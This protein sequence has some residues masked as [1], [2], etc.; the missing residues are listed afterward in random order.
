MG[1]GLMELYG[2]QPMF[3][4]P[5]Y[6]F[7]VEGWET[8]KKNLL[9]LAYE[10]NKNFKYHNNN[11]VSSTYDQ[12]PTSMVEK[13]SFIF[14]Q[15]IRLFL[16]STNLQSC[17]LNNVWFQRAQQGDMHDVHNHGPCGY[18]G[19]CYVEFDQKF[20]T[21]TKFISPFPNFLNGN[22]M[23]Y[24]PEVKEGSIVFFPSFVTHYTLPNHSSQERLILAFNLTNF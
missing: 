3:S 13:I 12:D 1:G 19:V 23:T 11:F 14:S 21:G 6:H 18:S 8:K 20:H 4:I 17:E 7:P 9:S 24:L 16:K 5:I 15:E 10:Q 2:S 22:L